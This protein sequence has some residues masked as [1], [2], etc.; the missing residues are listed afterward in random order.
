M[1]KVVIVGGGPAGRVVV[2]SLYAAKKEYD[3]VLIKDEEINVNRCSVPYGIVDKKPVEKYCISDS[4][5][6]EFGAKLVIDT[7]VEINKE[8]NFVVTEK[9][10]KFNYDYLLLATGSKPIILPIPGIDLD[11]ITSV[12]S[13][14]DLERLRKYAKEYK[15]CVVVGGGY[16]GVE[17]AVVLKKLGLDVTIVEMLPHILLATMD[18]DFAEI[19]EN[20]VK[21]KGINVM[22]GAKVVEFAGSEGKVKQVILEN[23]ERIDADFVIVSVGVVPNTEL[24]EKSG[25]EVSKFGVVTDDYLRTSVE[26]IFAAGDCAEKK[27]FI[28][29]KPTRGEFGTNAVFMSKVVGANIQ[30]KN[31]IFPGVINANASTAFEYSFGSAGLIQKMAEKEGLDI[32]VGE[33]EVLDMYPMMDGVDKIKTKLVFDRKTGK[34]I[35]GSVLRKGHCTANNVDFIS[36][37][38]QMGATIEDIMKYQYA[39]HPELAAKPS[40]NTYMFAARDALSKM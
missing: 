2:H 7:V 17:V 35:G 24:A 29:K 5:I 14:A 19:I 25:I 28:T 27:S 18:D 16:I 13:K 30:G 20:H 11:N 31:V 22:T 10:Q 38:I 3:V 36:F 33:S 40:D 26:N 1:E 6:T 23:G 21:E 39:T 32:V 37:A 4:L 8:E 9:G 34:L 15:K 12:R